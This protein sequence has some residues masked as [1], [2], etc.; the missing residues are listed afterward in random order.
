MRTIVVVILIILSAGALT[1]SQAADVTKANNAD[2]LNLTSSWSG[3]SVPGSGDVGV[4][5][6]TVTAANTVLL[7]GDLSWNGVRIANP[8]GLV[9]IGA[10]NTLTLDA[11]G[12][13][14]TAATQ[15][16]TANCALSLGAGQTWNIASGRTLTVGGAVSGSGAL[17][18]SGTGTL[19]L[20]VANNHTGG[21]AANAGTLK[22][23][24]SG[25]LGSP[26][27]TYL[28]TVGS[29][30]S[31][32]LA[33]VSISGQGKPVYINGA[34]VSGTFGA[35]GNS[36]GALVTSG[37]NNITLAGNASIGSNGNRF[38]LLGTLDG[39][40]NT[41][42]KIGN[43]DMASKGTLSNVSTLNINGGAWICE[44]D[45]ALGSAAVAVAGGTLRLWK[46]AG[47]LTYANNL[48]LNGGTFDQS[49]GGPHVWNG[50]L[51]LSGGNT[52]SGGSSVVVN[53]TVSGNG[54]INK[55]GTGTLTF[56]SGTPSLTDV[57]A[58]QG[59]LVVTNTAG[60]TVG[61]NFLVNNNGTVGSFSQGGGT[62]TF[63]GSLFRVAHYP[64]SGSYRITGG[65]LALGS[66]KVMRIGWDGLGQLFV[67]GGQ[68]SGAAA[69]LSLGNSG[70][71]GSGSS[72]TL[73]GSGA[74]TIQNFH[75][76]EA[77][78]RSGLVT[79]SGTSSVTVTG[80][81]RV[82]HYG[83]ETSTY[84]MNG[85]TV[86]LTA[87]SG[88]NPFGGGEQ[89]GAL[90]LGIDGTG[91]FN[92]SGGAVSAQGLV[93]DNRSDTAGTDTY[94]MT[95]GTLTLGAW[96][97]Q[98]NGTTLINLGG[99][100]LLASAAW[101]SS[102]PMTLTGT[103][104]D[105]GF[106]T[107][108]GNIT[109]SG[110]LSSTGGLNKLGAGTLQLSGNNTFTGTCLVTAG[111]L[112]LNGANGASP[113]GRN[114]LRIE[115]G[116]VVTALVANQL[117]LETSGYLTSLFVNGGQFNGDPNNHVNA[118][119]MN[120]GTIALRS[121]ATVQDGL[122]FRTFAAVTPKV[123][124]QASA[125]AATISLKGTLNN[126]TTFDVANG[127]ASP[128]LNY[129][130]AIVGGNSLTKTGAGTMRL[131]AQCSYTG[132][133]TIN[134]GTLQLNSGA[135]ASGCI[136][137]TVDVNS[138]ATLESMLQDTFGYSATGITT[139]NINGG[140]VNH[141]ANNNNL[142]LSAITIN[143]T[144]GT[145]Q[146][147][148]VG[149]NRFDFLDNSC[150]VNS[151]ASANTSTISGLIQLRA[152]QTLTTFTV[153]DGTANTDLLINAAFMEAA[154]GKAIAKAG[155]G[156]MVLSGVSSYTGNTT[157]NGGTLAI[158]N[159]GQIYS[160]LAWA[161]RTL[162][163]TSATLEIDGWN[164]A[165][166]LGQN[167]YAAGN[168]TLNGAILRFTGASNPCSG[169]TDAGNGRSFTI[170]AGGA[171]LESATAGVLW[172]IT[173]YNAGDSYP[174]AS[175][176]G[177]LTLTGAG[178]GALHKVIPGGGGLNKTGGGNWTLT[179][180]NT[181][182][183]ATTIGGGTLYVN[184]PGATGG[185]TVTVNNGGTLGGNGSI[186]GAV[187]VQTGGVLTPGGAAGSRETLTIN[188]NLVVQSG[189]TYAWDAN[190]SNCDKVQVNGDIT[191]PTAMTITVNASG[192]PLTTV[193]FEWTG[194]NLGATNLQDWFV[195]GGYRAQIVG[196]QVQLIPTGGTIFRVQ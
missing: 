115:S 127:T 51:T 44:T 114:S 158:V 85:G 151:L 117:G 144:G 173:Q 74:I 140:L 87:T 103:N 108:G 97:I 102:R 98:G 82:G 69:T 118:I 105:V 133:T 19:T 11:G 31:L 54:N 72:V 179:A 58:S 122:D 76:G 145:L 33:G 109:L 50:T 16:L 22:I 27:G 137:G 142:T 2:N 41:L 134:N 20:S 68:I 47:A 24:N 165:A 6:S 110:V 23:G 34:G 39:G 163:V 67:S 194:N 193:V 63:N 99:G 90:Y 123:T 29:G 177:M 126:A 146:S 25:A 139:L 141:T 192:T 132:G 159:G 9:T 4:W 55:T 120:G 12:V 169:P 77:G 35:I 5:D 60:L 153:A 46:S 14:L 148:G 171:T 15:N 83:S 152:G 149:I 167:S 65:T 161:S 113:A 155:A 128:D 190:A 101:A 100:T 112:E 154:T 88:A 175:A 178:S 160:N 157:V 185:G 176:G 57:V 125:S 32:D 162:G 42:T 186:G 184:A 182:A 124:V 111:T 8:G 93:L 75:L 119:T 181:Y 53:G 64:G 129:T 195:P 81:L 143:L 7:G 95:G 73:S 166:S 170:G 49:N 61:G 89:N 80:Q 116:A 36:G 79:Q 196:K 104:G 138:G 52:F 28:M 71:G 188:N 18:K 13:E 30:A 150:V 70:A 10:G 86:A 130:A 180:A 136:R 26:A 78:S 172:Q 147:T 191:L 121:G 48:T 168:L 131:G 91:V 92:H 3:G 62:V 43:C 106:N 135:S 174:L 96:G 45:N 66:G 156:R 56:A 21:T 107:S 94:T 189:T 183:G 187:T 84:N 17:S 40:G 59:Y 37:L 38:D 1:C 164:G